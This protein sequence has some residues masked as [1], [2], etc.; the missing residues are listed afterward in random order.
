MLLHPTIDKLHALRLSAMALALQDQMAT[1]HYASLSFE[2]RLGLLADRE[3][4]QRENIRLQGRLKRAKLRQSAAV[5]DI[6]FHHPRGL[7]KPLFLSLATCRWVHEK[8]TCIITGPTGAG[9]TYLACALAHKA[10]REGYRTLYFRASRMFEELALARADGRYPKLMAAY[11]KADLL[12]IDDWGLTPLTDEQ[13]KEMIEIL[14]DR[15]DLRAT[16]ITSQFPIEKWHTVVG[17]PTLADA[18]LDRLVH[19]AYKIT[20]KGDSLRKKPKKNSSEQ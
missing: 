16:L 4:T 3:T 13:R 18:I 8:H 10:C 7:D 2:D 19:H 11:A 20:L 6:D 12:V 15:Y 14:E 5:E 1:P 9:K 17:D